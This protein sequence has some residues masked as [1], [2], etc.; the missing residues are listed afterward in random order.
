[1]DPRYSTNITITTSIKAEDL[2]TCAELYESA[3]P[4]DERRP[5][6]EWKRYVQ[7]KENFHVYPFFDDNAHELCGFISFW[8]FEDFTYVEHFA[9]KEPYRGQGTGRMVFGIFLSLYD[10]RSLP[11]ILEVEPP[12]DDL[13]RS[14]IRFY[15]RCGMELLPYDYT[16]P[17]YTPQ[18]QP[19]PM[20][21][22]CS[23]WRITE[24]QV[25]HFVQG[26]REQVYG[27]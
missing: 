21:L 12:T 23:N 27:V 7:E 9:V 2:A 24:E 8:E 16:Q 4:A 17:P 20:R 15:E 10:A 14:R 19:L 1:M 5:T 11:V 25:K 3:F 13:T 22:M 26:I 18:Q 6:E